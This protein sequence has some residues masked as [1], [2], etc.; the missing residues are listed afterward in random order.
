M[1]SAGSGGG[2]GVGVAAVDSA[3]ASFPQAAACYGA[4]V[5]IGASGCLRSAAPAAARDA[6]RPSL[7]CSSLSS[8]FF[9]SSSRCA[10]GELPFQILDAALQR[11]R[12]AARRGVC[13]LLW[14]CRCR[15][16]VSRDAGGRSAAAVL[17]AAPRVHLAMHF[18]HRLGLIQ[19]RDFIA[20]RARAAQ[21]RARKILMLPPKASGFARYMA[22]MV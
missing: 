16:P 5:G 8:L 1:L 20:L 10:S 9:R 13:C 3:S 15:R 22:I 21:R 11:L 7:R 4:G 14:R 6:C 2:V 12:F 18:A 19:R 17:R